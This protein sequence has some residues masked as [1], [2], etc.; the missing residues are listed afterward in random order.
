MSVSIVTR[1]LRRPIITAA[2][3]AAGL[4]T[5]AS[6]AKAQFYPYSYYPAY[7]YGYGYPYAYPYYPA[8]RA[9]GYGWGRPCGR[10]RGWGWRH[11]WGGHRH[12]HW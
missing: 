10:H 9:A 6:P 3:L 2:F 5:T 12:R 1:A 7:S 4:L 8:Y 11:G